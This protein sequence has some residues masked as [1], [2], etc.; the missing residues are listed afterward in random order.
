MT[1]DW[2]TEG[3]DRGR[4]QTVVGLPEVPDRH[5]FAGAFAGVH[6]DHLLA[7]GGA[8][9]PDG[10]MPWN[11]G[12]KVWHDRVFALDLGARDAAWREIGRLPAPGGYGVSLTVPEGVLLIG[13]GD[14]TRHVA[15]VWLMTLGADRVSFRSLPALP[16]PLAQMAGA[17]VGRRVHIAGGVETPAATS[18][19]ARHWRLDLDALDAGWQ[20][21]PALPAPGRI[22]ATAAASGDAF[23]LVSGCSLA[24]DAAGGPV[25]TDLR[26]AWRFAGG[27]MDAACRSAARRPRPP[28]LRRPSSPVHCSS[29]GRRRNAALDWRRRSTTPASPARSCATR[30][31]TTDG[32]VPE[33]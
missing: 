33:S 10:V 14:A 20:S 6:R 3:R 31:P 9:F 2:L 15:D 16:V 29:F 12:T 4:S 18:A 23:Y 21:M 5:G 7:G 27:Q 19:S 17:V 24:A 28:R 30:R 22:L 11:G 8:N 1:L 32:P 25:R 26:D 13:G